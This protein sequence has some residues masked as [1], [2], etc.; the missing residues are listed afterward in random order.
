MSQQSQWSRLIFYINL[1]QC[2]I[3]FVWNY[4][5]SHCWRVLLLRL[6]WTFRW[7]YI[8]CSQD[9]NEYHFLRKT[10]CAC[11]LLAK[12][13]I[14]MDTVVNS[15]FRSILF[16]RPFHN[17]N[18]ALYLLTL[19]PKIIAGL[20]LWVLGSGKEVCHRADTITFKWLSV[21]TSKL[22]AKNAL[23]LKFER[24]ILKMKITWCKCLK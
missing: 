12:V 1:L 13:A 17:W 7:K 3:S 15:A 22:S 21:H 4:E 20:S 10:D 9:H 6:L 2:A 24:Y 14:A 19:I 16:Y 5:H 8:W 18:N 23:A 11:I